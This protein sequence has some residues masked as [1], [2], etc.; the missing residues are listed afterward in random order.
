MLSAF[1]D[2]LNVLRINVVNTFRYDTAYFWTNIFSVLS[3]VTYALTYL[4]F[5]GVIYGKVQTVAGYNHNEILFF[6]FAGTVTFFV[7]YTWCYDSLDQLRLDVN[8]GNLDLLLTKPMPLLF[9]VSTRSTS[10]L[11]L[12]KESGLP[13]FIIALTI[14]WPALDFSFWPVLAGVIIFFLSIIIFH[15]IQF[16]LTIPVFWLGESAEISSLIYGISDFDLPYEGFPR[17]LKF[18][19]TYFLPVLFGTAIPT[20]VM[21]GKTNASVMLVIAL[22]VTIMFMLLRLWGWKMA[23]KNYTSASS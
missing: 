10:L 18:S 7:L 11:G 2:R 4:L 17:V 5:I 23:L 8:R 12:I 6:I 21:L 22:F 13:M 1:S 16:L 9:Y 15:C 3:A 19:L 20:S 14:D